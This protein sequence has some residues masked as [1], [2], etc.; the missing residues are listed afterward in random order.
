MVI[1][2][3]R[4]SPAA[5]SSFL[6]TTSSKNGPA[7]TSSETC[8]QTDNSAELDDDL[9]AAAQICQEEQRG[10]EHARV[11]MR[12]QNTKLNNFKA[13]LI[14]EAQEL[15]LPAGGPINRICE[16]DSQM[17]TIRRKLRAASYVGGGQNWYKLFNSIDHGSSGTI[18]L[19]EFQQAMRRIVKVP[20]LEVHDEELGAVQ[21]RRRGQDGD[22]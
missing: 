22:D 18:N 19:E 1:A 6:G 14:L 11:E 8:K 12:I 20:V 16:N 4:F 9:E 7:A 15:G 3:Q 21:F 13:Q 5:A 10:I 17:S 2:R